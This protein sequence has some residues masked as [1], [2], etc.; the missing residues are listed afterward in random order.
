MVGAAVGAVGALLGDCV[1]L[2]VVGETL[3][4]RVDLVGL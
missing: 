1:G 2:S 4:V 3:G